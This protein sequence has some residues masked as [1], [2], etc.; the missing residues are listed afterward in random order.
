MTEFGQDAPDSNR[1]NDCA[2]SGNGQVVVT[3][4]TGTSVAFT[5]QG[6]RAIGFAS[7]YSYD[8]IPGATSTDWPQLGVSFSDAT[9]IPTSVAIDFEGITV[10]L[11][12]SLNSQVRVR[13]CDVGTSNWQQLAQ[14]I[15]EQVANEGFGSAVSLSDN[16]QH[17]AVTAP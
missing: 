11:G 4:D 10:A 5:G 1:I 12:S 2:I 3:V 6:N 16:G 8:P 13:R 9:F 15:F 7:A 17:L 14:D